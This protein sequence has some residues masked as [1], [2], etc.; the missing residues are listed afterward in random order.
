MDVTG[1]TAIITG[2]RRGIGRSIALRLAEA[3]ANIV[4]CDLDEQECKRVVDEAKVHAV[5][6]LAL[7]TDVTKIEEV[8]KLI[9]KTLDRFGK[10]DILVNNSGT[11]T[12]R[13]FLELTEE[14]LDRHLDVNFKGTFYCS[15]LAAREMIKQQGGKIINIAS[16]A[17]EI[18]LR[19]H[20]AYAV[21]KAG[22]IMLT[23]SIARELAPYRIN[24]NCVSPGG[25]ETP[26]TED[27]YKDARTLERVLNII[28]RHEIGKPRHIA[29]AVLF[30]AS[31]ASDY[32]TGATLRVDGGLTQGFTWL[33]FD[34][35]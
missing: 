17:G 20:S 24:V 35:K 28:P 23:R 19:N 22:V 31:D 15:Q 27:L 9:E 18:P 2:S 21:S 1:K 8:R 30:L 12:L 16:I 34:W 13:P 7:R 6:G 4:V 25:I 14:E 11:I 10:I 29:E 33:P 32:I 26:M 5:D 3:G